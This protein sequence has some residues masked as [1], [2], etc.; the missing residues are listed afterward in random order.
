MLGSEVGLAV[1]FGDGIGEAVDLGRGARGGFS[2]W[3]GLGIAGCKTGCKTEERRQGFGLQTSWVTLF[4][5][6]ET[7]QSR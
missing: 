3:V 5:G 6:R 7:V 4:T 1:H 2:R